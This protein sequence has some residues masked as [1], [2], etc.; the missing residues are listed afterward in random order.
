ME[1]EVLV[2]GYRNLLASIYS[3]KNYYQRIGTFLKSY[4]PTAKTRLGRQDMM[5][6]LRSAWGLGVVSNVRF[7]YWRLVV[8]TFIVKRKALP[9]AVDLAIMGLHF[10]KVLERVCQ[11]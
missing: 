5:A 6:F 9:L 10:E 1:R 4:N 3:L 7:R 11:A 2:K 8:K